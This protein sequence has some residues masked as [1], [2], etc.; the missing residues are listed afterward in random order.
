MTT[1]DIIAC[2]DTRKTGKLLQLLQDKRIKEKF[3][4]EFGVSVDDFVENMNATGSDFGEK[5]N[6][7]KTQEK[8]FSEL[9]KEVQEDDEIPQNVG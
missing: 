8:E 9:I 2:E 3:K 7:S 6:Q 4:S 1:C 5:I